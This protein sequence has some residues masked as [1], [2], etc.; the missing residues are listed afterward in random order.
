MKIDELIFEQS[1][2]PEL[3]M[4]VYIDKING[5]YRH[6]AKKKLAN[7]EIMQFIGW[8]NEP[9]KPEDIPYCNFFSV[10]SPRPYKPGQACDGT[11]DTVVIALFI[12]FCE[13]LKLNPSLIYAEAYPGETLTPDDCA[14][15]KKN[16]EWEGIAYPIKWTDKNRKLLAQS[17]HNANNHSL[18][19]VL[20]E[21]ELITPQIVML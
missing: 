6:F 20:Y 15:T 9:Q 14:L 21:N 16:A 8:D 11:I 2:I 10:T 18:A 12:H 13:R 19:N 17:L 4:M 5:Q 3:N 1:I 7:G